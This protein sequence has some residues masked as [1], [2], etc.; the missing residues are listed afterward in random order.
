M[1]QTIT[2]VKY[3]QNAAQENDKENSVIDMIIKKDIDMKIQSPQYE[4]EF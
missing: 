3:V 1:N 4:R 2:F